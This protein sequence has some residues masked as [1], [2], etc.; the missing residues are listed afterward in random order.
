M[1]GAREYGL[2]ELGIDPRKISDASLETVKTLK[3]RNHEAF[4]VGGAVRDLLLGLDPKDYDVA[5]DARP[6][7]VKRLFRRAYVIGRRFRLVHVHLGGETVEVS[8]FRRKPDGSESEG[9][10]NI[11]GTASEDAL[12]RD[13]TVNALMLDPVRKKVLDFTDGI[14]DVKR[15]T[16]RVI[17]NPRERYREDPVRMMRLLRLAAKLDCSISKDSLRPVRRMAH[18]LRDIPPARLFDEFTKVALSKA[19]S[20]TFSMFLEHGIAEI[21]FPHLANYDGG[22]IEFINEVLHSTD[23]ISR[24]NGRV[25]LSLVTCGLFWPRIA[26]RWAEA[27][28]ANEARMNLMHELFFE[29]GIDEAAILPRSLRSKAWEIFEF[30]SRF[31]NQKG[32]PR[33]LKIDARNYTTRK[34]LAFLRLRNEAGEIDSLLPD[35]WEWFFELDHAERSKQVSGPARKKRKRRGRGRK[36]GAKRKAADGDPRD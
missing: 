3:R 21:L 8:T 34:A 13:F 31:Q 33:A 23:H 26:E 14:S 29:S 7:Q 24:R 16:M 22:Q 9:S 2:A 5:T 35:W 15:R 25:S 12:R 11:F 28:A 6:N 32:K 17:G 19:S 10:E 36:G 27:C 1:R 20:R 30:Q 18:A 4:L